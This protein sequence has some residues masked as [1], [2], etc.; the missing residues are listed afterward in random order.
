MCNFVPISLSFL[1]F[2][3][4]CVSFEIWV[5]TS[6]LTVGS[7]TRF[8]EIS[9]FWPLL[10]SLHSSK[11]FEPTLVNF[12]CYWAYFHCCKCSFI[13]QIIWAS[14]HTDAGTDVKEKSFFNNSSTR[15]RSSLSLFQVIGRSIDRQRWPTMLFSVFWQVLSDFLEPYLRMKFR[16]TFLVILWKSVPLIRSQDGI[17]TDF[18]ERMSSIPE[19]TPSAPRWP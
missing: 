5:R 13:Y 1:F 2:L 14:G 17:A 9:P 8:D 18:A 19:L 3:L 7:V 10:E 12:I 15:W 6:S 16:R 4:R 11:N